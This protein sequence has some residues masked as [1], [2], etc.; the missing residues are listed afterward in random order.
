MNDIVNYA[1]LCRALALLCL[2]CAGA[3]AFAAGALFFY[4]RQRSTLHRYLRS[5]GGRKVSLLLAAAVAAGLLAGHEVVFAAEPEKTE[6]VGDGFEDE[7]TEYTEGGGSKD[8]T[9]SAGGDGRDTANTDA[10][11]SGSSRT[12]DGGRTDSAGDAE[13]GDDARGAGETGSSGGAAQRTEEGTDGAEG[14]QEDAAEAG[15][16]ENGTGEKGG[17][18][19]VSDGLEEDP[20]SGGELSDETDPVIEVLPED[21]S[22]KDAAGMVYF[23]EDNAGLMIR[24]T[25]SGENDK[26]L[27]NCH[28]AVTG[29]SG[30]TI[31]KGYVWAQEGEK[32]FELVLESRDI[33][34]LGDGRIVIKVTAEDT[35]G[36]RSEAEEQFVLDTQNPVLHFEIN[37]PL[38]N[39]AAV[40]AASGIVYYGADCGQYAS[41]V[42]EIRAIF[43][44]E[45][46]NL[47]AGLL[48]CRYTA[49][50]MEYAENSG[51]IE[52]QAEEAKDGRVLVSKS[53]LLHPGEQDCPD[54]SYRF[55]IS[56]ADMAGN[57]LKLEEG[58]STDPV[59]SLFCTDEEEGNFRSGVKI[60]DTKAPTAVLTVSAGEVFYRARIGGES[61]DVDGEALHPYQSVPEAVVQLTG[62]D[63]S[64][65]C[66]SWNIRSTNGTRNE[67]PD[68]KEPDEQSYQMGEKAE[69]V[70]RGD[71]VFWMES[72]SVRDRAGNVSSTLPKTS[73]LYL[74]T[75]SPSSDLVSPSAT[76][77][78][79][80]EVTARE[81]DG[82]PLFDSSVTLQ[83]SAGDPVSEISGT[84]LQEVVC[85]VWAGAR[86]VVRSKRLYAAKEDVRADFR[87]ELT[88]PAGGEFET[89]QI[90]VEVR[91]TDRAGNSSDPENG[92]VF[93]FG[94]DTQGPSVTVTFADETENRAHNGQY[95]S[96]PRSAVVRL[97]DRNPGN[98][99][100]RLVSQDA[101]VSPWQSVRGADPEGSLDERICTVQW[102]RDGAYTLEV[103][104]ADALGNP[105][106]VRYEG[107]AAQ[108]F[109]I[110]QTPP[111]IE[112]NWEG[113]AAFNIIYYNRPRAAR[114][115][116]REDNFSARGIRLLPSGLAGAVWKESESPD[117]S[118]T[119]WEGIVMFRSE[120][121]WR[122][123]CA[124]T[125]LAGNTAA[126][127]ASGEFVIDMTPPVLHFDENSLQGGG[128]YAGEVTPRLL[129]GDENLEPDS[130]ELRTGKCVRSVSD[131]ENMSER[132]EEQNLPWEYESRTDEDGSILLADA[133]HSRDEDGLW[134]CEA[135][136]R[137]LAGNCS[138]VKRQ[139]CLNRCG[140]VYDFTPGSGTENLL[141]S[142]YINAE[143]PV[144]LTE[145]AG[146]RL[147]AQRVILFRNGES[148]QLEEGKEYRT[149]QIKAGNGY[150]Y[151]YEIFPSCFAQDGRYALTLESEDAAGHSNSSAADLPLRW[152]V[153]GTAPTCRLT[154][155]RNGQL[156]YQTD[157]LTVKILPSDELGISSVTVSLRKDD[158]EILDEKTYQGE[159]LETVLLHNNGGVPFKIEA[160]GD[161]QTLDAKVTDEAGNV[162]EMAPRRVLVTSDPLVILYRS[163]IFPA[164]LLIA[165]A[166]IVS[167]PAFH[168][169]FTKTL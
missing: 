101:V 118:G 75:A 43:T 91:A 124:V 125:D 116:V 13:D 168:S 119:Y 139:Y 69:A 155:L 167:I 72:V 87:T 130:I 143:D 5:S 62:E 92:G 58:S 81:S 51:R 88:I 96:G 103:S 121:K 49:D 157:A 52:T 93:L 64:P 57:P 127:Y 106:S 112:V 1:E 131:D 12:S 20:E 98:E 133:P 123:G 16:T 144:E 25:E 26:G 94:I 38:D 29:E 61:V 42:P 110:D 148:R 8:E 115:R 6:T 163:G 142:Y 17:N 128:A 122:L 151:R 40:D 3:C 56:G 59:N 114:V 95:F 50:G 152:A 28:I 44:A 137:D 136:A 83:I 9:D 141:H 15:E 77:H 147:L 109:T 2:I 90:R 156:R 138:R 158:G 111:V 32:R 135:S 78:A 71:Q 21:T 60:V 66:L 36:N 27:G 104:G 73:R 85:D 120:G 146:S 18:G 63:S 154:G 14:A 68:S 159:E 31:A 74:D 97:R 47:D 65:I 37:R 160:S 134:I 140:S 35:S 132:W 166:V 48:S 54:G 89:N 86:H 108:A 70:I 80:G 4:C 84:G 10:G 145:Y 102:L 150:S 22:H 105:A 55:L 100:V 153:D 99:A 19:T 23:R 76:V 33:A 11:E 82:R 53:I 107:E 126:P 67:V 113:G 41:G 79:L 39:D 164:I 129:C 45:D 34:A 30:E 162:T 46:V 161:W 149:E 7:D 169:S 24:I 117:S 165:A